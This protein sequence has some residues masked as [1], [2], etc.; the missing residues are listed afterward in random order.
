MKS[1]QTYTLEMKKI[2]QV[3]IQGECLSCTLEQVEDQ[4]S[5]C[6]DKV[7]LFECVD[8]GRERKQI[9]AKWI[10]KTFGKTFKDLIYESWA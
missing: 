7:D 3:N 2:C 1:N 9:C 8:E 5:E 4:I 6:E 10:N